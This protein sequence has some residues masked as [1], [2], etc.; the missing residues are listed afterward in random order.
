MREE[1]IEALEDDGSLLTAK[2]VTKKLTMLDSMRMSNGTRLIVTELT[3]KMCWRMADLISL[4]A[5][6]EES[7]PLGQGVTASD[8]DARVSIDGSIPPAPELSM[9]EEDKE[10]MSLRS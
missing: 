6:A 9:E 5:S 4:H 10:M 7:L 2:N 3:M 1:L 8:L